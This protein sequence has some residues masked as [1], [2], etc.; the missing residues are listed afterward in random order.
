MEPSSS[1][2]DSTPTKSPPNT[3]TVVVPIS[4]GKA[5]QKVEFEALFKYWSRKNISNIPSRKIF[6][7]VLSKLLIAVRILNSFLFFV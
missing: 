2:C 4:P 3:Q 5:A 6:D 7:A 1:S